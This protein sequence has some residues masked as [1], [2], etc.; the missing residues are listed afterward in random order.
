MK[1]KTSTKK[2]KW[3]I[4]FASCLGILIISLAV[5]N[6]YILFSTPK[7]YLIKRENYID[8]QVHYECAGYSSAYVLRSLG[9]EITGLELYQ[10]I[11]NKNDDG[12]VSPDNLVEFLTNA[13]YH[14]SLKTGTIYQLK[15]EVSKGIPVIAF[16]KIAP[17]ENY[18]HYLP[19]VGYDQENIYTA[20]SLKY[21]KNVENEYYNRVINISDFKD[22]WETGIFR[23]NTYITIR[24]K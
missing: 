21:K 24:L 5:I 22:M 18:Y 16:V 20:D 17:G 6:L 10:S 8:Y 14:A 2:I 1:Q 12:T 23:K 11:A 13:G 19:V 9:K 15:H 4:V 3:I 7:D